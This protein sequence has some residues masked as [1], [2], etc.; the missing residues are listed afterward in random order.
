MYVLPNFKT[1]KALKKAVES[2]ETVTVFQP[3][4]VGNEVPNNTKVF[5]EGPHF[6]KKVTWYAQVIVKGGKITK[7]L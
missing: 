3:N 5:V 4:S 1:K 2:G 6:P 7:V